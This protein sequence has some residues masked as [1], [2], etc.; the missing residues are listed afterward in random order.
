[1][2]NVCSAAANNILIH[3]DSGDIPDSINADAD[4]MVAVSCSADGTLNVFY[5]DENSVVGSQLQATDV[6]ITCGP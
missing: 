6:V 2:A 4:E 1:M 3:T 5:L